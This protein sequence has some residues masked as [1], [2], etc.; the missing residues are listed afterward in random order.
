M[1]SKR[2][3]SVWFLPKGHITWLIKIFIQ[4]Y[5]LKNL[6]IFSVKY[7]FYDNFLLGG[8]LFLFLFLSITQM[9]G[10]SNSLW[11]NFAAL[12]HLFDNS[13]F[14]I[15][16]LL[17]QIWIAHQMNKNTLS[18]NLNQLQN[19]QGIM[20]LILNYTYLTLSFVKTTVSNICNAIKQILTDL[21]THLC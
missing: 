6:Q 2:A 4:I 20:R 11:Q 19:R 9:F 21:N 15:Y 16:M 1:F 5:L 18:L 12:L 14:F 8:W 3:Y 10:R 13:F 7:L 17:W